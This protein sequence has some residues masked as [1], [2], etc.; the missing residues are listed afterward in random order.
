MRLS[1]NLHVKIK[2][3]KV[4]KR[5]KGSVGMSYISTQKKNHTYSMNYVNI[6]SH[7]NTHCANET[8]CK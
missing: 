8:M 6:F 7:N 3:S 1:I 4:E 5:V 2:H